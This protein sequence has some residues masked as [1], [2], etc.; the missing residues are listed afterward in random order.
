M[1]MNTS[2]SD[3]DSVLNVGHYAHN[4]ARKCPKRKLKYL[5][6]RQLCHE[7]TNAVSALRAYLSSH[8]FRGHK[9]LRNDVAK[10]VSDD[11]RERNKNLS[12]AK[13]LSRASR[14][15]T[16][17]PNH[18]RATCGLPLSQALAV[19]SRT[20][21]LGREQET[22]R[23][24][25]KERCREVTGLPEMIIGLHE[26]LMLWKSTSNSPKQLFLCSTSHATRCTI[27]SPFKNRKN[28]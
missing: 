15:T 23:Q 21:V 28:N 26:L 4:H 24:L 8:T 1:A 7:F 9:Q 19:W 11:G 13:T 10:Q 2:H 22:A 27:V 3:R 17:L 12:W 20:A 6:R 25:P 14:D 16:R 18:A 5:Q